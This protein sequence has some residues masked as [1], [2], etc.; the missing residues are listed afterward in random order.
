MLVW[1]SCKHEIEK[2]LQPNNPEQQAFGAVVDDNGS[3]QQQLDPKLS[4]TSPIG[5]KPSDVEALPIT[6]KDVMRSKYRVFR[7]A[8]IKE[9]LDGHDQIGT[10]TKIK[11]L[12]K[13][14]KAVSSKWVFAWKTNEKGLIVGFKARMVAR[15]FSQIPGVDFHHS[16]SACPSGASIKTMMVVSTEK[17]KKL[18]HWDVKQA[19]VHAKLK[20]EVYLRF[21]EGCGNL[22][23]K[24]FRSSGHCMV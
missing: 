24:V 10:F 19:Y 17:R 12:P 9:E 11:G 14:R 15:G 2:V 6:Y 20:E 18:V 7:E 16:S 13:G 5:Q 21:P 23:G 1:T 8:A 4:M 22:T 3:S